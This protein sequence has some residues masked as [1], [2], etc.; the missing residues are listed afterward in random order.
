[1]STAIDRTAFDAIAAALSDAWNAADGAGFAKQFT[2][3]ADFVNIY[4]MHGR[5]REAI[6]RAHQAIF[7]GVYRGSTNT[8]TVTQARRVN[9]DV[10]LVHI[11]ADLHVPEGVMAGDLRALATAVMVRDEAG[12]KIAAFHNTREQAPPGPP[13]R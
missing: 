6:A 9:D 13:P 8:F 5:G 10:T 7:D 11:A 12:W 2:D 4:A 1:M 3:D